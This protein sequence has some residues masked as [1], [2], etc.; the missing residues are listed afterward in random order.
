MAEREYRQIHISG[1]CVWV[2]RGRVIATRIFALMHTRPIL[3]FVCW[4]CVVSAGIAATLFSVY[5]PLVAA[6]LAGGQATPAQIGLT[7]SAAGSAFLIGWAIGA[8]VIGALADRIG[9][10]LALFTGVLLCSVGV[11]VT[12]YA[13]S[14]PILVAIRFLTGAGAGSVLLLAAVLISEAWATGNRARMV[15]IMMNAFPVGLIVAGVIAQNVASWRTAYLL[16]GS[17]VLLAA[18][19]LLVVRESEWWLQSEQAPSTSHTI[20]QLAQP[21]LRRDVVIGS[22]LFGAM[23]VGLWAVFVWMPTW[24]HKLSASEMAQKNRGIANIMLGAGSLVGGLLSGPLSNAAG[25][26]K[27]AA[28]GYCGCLVLTAVTFVSGIPV[29]PMMFSLA[30]VL[31]VCIGINQGVL[32]TYLNE[33]FPTRVRA[34]AT[35]VCMNGGRLVTAVTVIFVGVLVEVLGGYNNAIVVFSLAYVVGLVTLLFARETKD[36]LLPA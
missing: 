23:L 2:P 16:G 3:F 6:E 15:G 31:S 4:M 10:R 21:A 28:L 24:V 32:G 36:A 22:V 1:G 18:A 19:V 12:A 34:Q 33:L 20:R 17:T 14:L 8:L 9:R 13:T 7:G 5:L 29:G 11:F 26:R 25:R 35:A 27:A 30:F